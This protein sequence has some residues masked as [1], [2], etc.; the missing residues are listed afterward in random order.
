MNM[1]DLQRVTLVDNA[2]NKMLPPMRDQLGEAQTGYSN[3]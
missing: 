1:V 3:C 2:H